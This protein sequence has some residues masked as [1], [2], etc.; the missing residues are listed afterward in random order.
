M[1][2]YRAPDQTNAGPPHGEPAWR[3]PD[4]PPPTR[5]LVRGWSKTGMAELVPACSKR[6]DLLDNLDAPCRT[7]RSRARIE[8]HDQGGTAA[9]PVRLGRR[10]VDRVAGQWAL[11][12]DD[13]H[14]RVD[15]LPGAAEVEGGRVR[16]GSSRRRLPRPRPHDALGDL[17][18]TD[19]DLVSHEDTFY[20]TTQG[21]V[22]AW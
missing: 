4:E 19:K 21:R 14:V 1:D 9:P 17:G 13:V 18:T 11:G 15:G 6:P 10:L 7:A 3:T 22:L 2:S 5:L 8:T 16:P 12:L 20:R